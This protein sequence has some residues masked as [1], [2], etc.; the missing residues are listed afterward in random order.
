MMTMTSI[1][2][3]TNIDA[4]S[5]TAVAR[6]AVAVQRLAGR[7]SYDALKSPADN[8][9]A[10]GYGCRRIAGPSRTGEREIYRLCDNRVVGQMTCPEATS[11]LKALAAARESFSLVDGAPEISR[12]DLLPDYC[13]INF[14]SCGSGILIQ[15][16]SYAYVRREGTTAG[17]CE[18]FNRDLGL[19]P[20]QVAA[21][22]FGFISGWTA[23]FADPRH[24]AHDGLPAHL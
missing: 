13:M 10:A 21:M 20:R 22:T 14:A 12:F 6:N 17:D 15:Q 11:W 18:K 24:P 3:L 8:L 19:I 4:S 23:P 2:Q 7:F 9:S 1:N 16:R 5:K